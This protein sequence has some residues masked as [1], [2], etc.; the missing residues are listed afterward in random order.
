MLKF[1]A[2]PLGDKTSTYGFTLH[3]KKSLDFL[4]SRDLSFSS[5]RLQAYNVLNMGCTLQRITNVPHSVARLSN[6]W[7]RYSVR[8]YAFWI[9][10]FFLINLT[11]NCKLLIVSYNT[12]LV[13]NQTVLSIGFIKFK[14]NLDY[15]KKR[16]DRKMF[17]S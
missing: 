5:S 9:C 14:M 16:E 8:T 10:V 4:F 1:Q 15:V 11:K 2:F 3:W 6:Y 13:N 12:C 7:A 17:S